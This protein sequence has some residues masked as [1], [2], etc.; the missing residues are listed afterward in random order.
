[1]VGVAPKRGVGAVVGRRVEVAVG[2]GL[3]E[4]VR[5]RVADGEGV[6]VAVAN[7]DGVLVGL[8]VAV[9]EDVGVLVGLA[10]A[11]GEDVG[12]LVGL[13]VAVGEDVGVLVGLAVAVGEDVGV[14][15]GLAVAVGEDV[16]VLVGVSVAVGD[17]VIVA[18]GR[19][20]IVSVIPAST[21]TPVGL[22][23]GSSWSACAPGCKA[24]RKPR[25]QT[26][27][28][29]TANMKMVA[30]WVLLTVPLPIL[31]TRPGLI[32][33]HPAPARQ[34][35]PAANAVTPP[36][37]ARGADEF[38]SRRSAPPRSQAGNLVRFPA[39][40]RADSRHIGRFHWRELWVWEG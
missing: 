15:V 10:V 14:L 17:G 28:T 4:R 35:P 16:G 37:C 3:G 2:V 13:A 22:T 18:D 40:R 11:V 27:T 31:H 26:A 20:V 7:G 33:R 30:R 39:T 29:M 32:M 36:R 8:A 21:S 5:V 12:V 6:W 25:P 19:G 9:G 38:A 1:M 23:P 24:A 34:I